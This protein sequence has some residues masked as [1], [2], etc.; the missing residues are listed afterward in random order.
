M[1][2]W[3][4][5]GLGA[6]SAMPEAQPERSQVS[7]ALMR[8]GD[9]TGRILATG[10]GSRAWFRPSRTR[11]NSKSNNAPTSGIFC[12]QVLDPPS[13]R[14]PVG[15]TGANFP[16]GLPESRRPRRRRNRIPGD[17]LVCPRPERA[18]PVR[19]RRSGRLPCSPARKPGHS[20]YRPSLSRR[21][22]PGAA[23]DTNRNPTSAIATAATRFPGS[24]V[25]VRAWAAGVP[26]AALRL[27][28]K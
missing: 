16:V 20:G 19:S 27:S 22:L 18:A 24:P 8:L 25:T 5:S 6:S 23:T 17:W 14:A 11:T 28:E 3:H 10:R 12:P 21:D 15:S 1:R 7:V 13:A 26:N 9:G 2:Q 4:I